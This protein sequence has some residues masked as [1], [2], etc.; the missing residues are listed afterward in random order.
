M[1][2]SESLFITAWEYQDKLT[3]LQEEINLQLSA[4][5]LSLSD[6]LKSSSKQTLSQIENNTFA[7]LNQDDVVR[8]VVFNLDP[9]ACTNNL[10]TVLDGVTEFSG[11]PSSICVNRYDS[12]VQ[13]VLNDTYGMLEQNNGLFIEVQQIVVRSFIRQ[14]AFLTPKAIIETFKTQYESLTENWAKNYPNI[15]EFVKTLSSKFAAI[16]VVLGSCFNET[17]SSLTPSYTRI[18]AE[19]EICKEFDNTKS[20]FAK[21]SKSLQKNFL[22][23]EDILPKI[24]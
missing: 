19:V 12:A 10:R 3:T 14:N 5:R 15:E 21:F 4:V 7:I 9:T 23:L 2:R 8:E 20:P 24:E 1:I 17:Q 16:N 11:F 6:V 18:I 13:S 22:K